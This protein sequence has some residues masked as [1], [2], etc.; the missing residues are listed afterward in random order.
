MKV[1][2]FSRDLSKRNER[3]AKIMEDK[4]NKKKN[5]YGDGSVYQRSD[6]RWVAKY[7]PDK[8]A[9][10][11]TK[12]FL[13]KKEANSGLKVIKQQ[14]AKG[15]QHSN[16]KVEVLMETWLETFRSRALRPGSYDAVE[17]NYFCHIKP[18]IGDYQAHQITSL[19]LQQLINERA[20]NLG[21]SSLSKVFSILM[22]FFNYITGEGLIERDPMNAVSMPQ[23]CHTVQSKKKIKYLEIDEIQ[24]IEQV[25]EEQIQK[26]WKSNRWHRNSVAKYGY[27]VLFLINTGLRKGEMLALEWEDLWEK[28]K[29][30]N[31]D[32]N[33]TQ[34]INRNRK[35]GESK[36]TWQLGDPKTKTSIRF[37]SYN[38]KARYYM[39]ELRRIQEHV[40]YADDRHIAR[41]PNGEPLSKSTWTSLLK[42]IC[43]L[44]EIDKSISPH[45]LRHTYATVCISKGINPLVVSRRMGHASLEQTYDY[46]HLLK[47][48]EKDADEMLENLLSE[49]EAEKNLILENSNIKV[50]FIKT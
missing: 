46:V 25:V 27:I 36:H 7:K 43:E 15:I 3:Q 8:G 49:D 4:K 18:F 24:R 16:Q 32:K 30:V 22:K 21:Y 20:E 39:R 35:E 2:K 28:K 1:S 13:T 34:V 17:S 48:I 12:T 45:M 44:A 14:A 6:G 19:I 38:K 37:A 42:Q 31:I 9:K 41:T 33:L 11:I 40:G 23:E 47:D 10:Y 29:Y 50:S 5:R 26:A